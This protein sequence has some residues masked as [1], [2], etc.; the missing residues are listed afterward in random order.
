MQ[1]CP[2]RGQHEPGES[3]GFVVGLPEV[4]ER[5]VTNGRVGGG[6]VVPAPDVAEERD[7][8]EYSRLGGE[9]SRMRPAEVASALGPGS[10][11]H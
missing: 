10:C 1:T 8:A 5:M 6:G 2:N 7:A 4:D 11:V 3:R 9:R